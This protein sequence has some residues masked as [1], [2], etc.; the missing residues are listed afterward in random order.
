MAEIFSK[1]DATALPRELGVVRRS[2]YSLGDVYLHAIDF[3][4][5][6]AEA[7]RRA[8]GLR[9]FQTISTDL[10]AHISAYDEAQW[11]SPEDS[12]AR[13]FYRWSP[14]D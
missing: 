6:P 14:A 12:F 8:R 10:R 3:K 9:E 5:D 4:S 1:S 13:E 11:R 2:L 7:L